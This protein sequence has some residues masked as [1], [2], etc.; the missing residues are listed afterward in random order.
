MRC[1][2]AIFSSAQDN[3]YLERL[4]IEADFYQL[5]ELIE[6]VSSEI[7]R[8]KS[9]L[10]N[11]DTPSRAVNKVVGVAELDRFLQM[12]WSYV[13][14]FEANDTT[15]CTALGEKVEAHYR[16]NR[17]TGCG[18]G[19]SFEK[20]NMHVSFF[21]PTMI[22]VQKLVPNRSSELA[23]ANGSDGLTMAIGDLVFDQS[24]G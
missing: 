12:G 24:F 4:L 5:E 20:F 11:I 15:G 16:N 3:A 8:R 14:H 7:V 21:R 6:Y 17:C 9:A 23:T 22:V 18:V 2:K 10:E 19:M 13:G 1:G